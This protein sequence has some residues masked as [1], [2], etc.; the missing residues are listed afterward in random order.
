MR[1]HSGQ[2]RFVVGLQDQAG[3]NEE[4]SARKSECVDFLGIENFDCERDFRV[5]IAYQVLADAVYVFRDDRIVDDLRGPLDF[6]GVLLTDRDFFLDR[7]PVNFAR[8]GAIADRI[9]ILLLVIRSKP[10]PGRRQD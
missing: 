1:H 8:N 5:R 9:R 3:V 7:V 6:L 2:F 10:E 4:E